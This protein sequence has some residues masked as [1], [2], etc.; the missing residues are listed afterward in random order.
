MTSEKERGV[1]IMEESYR[2]S[3]VWRKDAI[4]RLDLLKQKI[5]KA[6][7]AEEGAGKGKEESQV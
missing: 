6:K 2:W 7:K 1:L 5:D 3:Q 4:A